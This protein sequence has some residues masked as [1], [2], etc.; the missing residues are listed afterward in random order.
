MRQSEPDPIVT[1]LALTINT[2]WRIWL[3]SRRLAS[4]VHAHGSSARRSDCLYQLANIAKLL[5]FSSLLFSCSCT[6]ARAITPHM[7]VTSTGGAATAPVAVSWSARSESCTSAA[8]IGPPEAAKL[9]ER[10]KGQGTN[11]MRAR[12]RRRGGGVSWEL[13]GGRIKSNHITSRLDLRALLLFVPARER[14]GKKRF[15]SEPMP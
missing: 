12:I 14:K 7:Q 11:T 10:Q 6:P 9:F 1:L 2:V 13:E 5:V 3:R 4:R 8:V 15:C